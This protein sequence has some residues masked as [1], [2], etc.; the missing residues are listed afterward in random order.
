MSGMTV[1]VADLP[2]GFL[3][4]TTG[5]TILI[6]RDAAGYGWFVDPTPAD[7]SE[8]ADVLGPG[9]LAANNSSPAAN[10]ADLLTAVMHEMGH[11]LGYDHVADGLMSATLPLGT[12]RD[13]N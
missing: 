7:D 12:R 6:D 3:G 10:R 2:S 11:V 1:Q 9:T 4:E 5:K 8:F 13:P